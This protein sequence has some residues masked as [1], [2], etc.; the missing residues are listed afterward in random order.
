MVIPT[1]KVTPNFSKAR[2]DEREGVVL[3]MKSIAEHSDGGKSSH[4]SGTEENFSF[5]SDNLTVND[6][7]IEMKKKLPR[8]MGNRFNALLNSSVYMLTTLLFTTCFIFER[9]YLI[10]TFQQAEKNKKPVTEELDF[11]LAFIVLFGIDAIGKLAYLVAT[12]NRAKVEQSR[13]GQATEDRLQNP[14]E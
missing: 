12:R 8:S 10:M 7:E 11:A 4:N 13:D 5:D 1:N 6:A 14:T 3:H 9:L 2:S